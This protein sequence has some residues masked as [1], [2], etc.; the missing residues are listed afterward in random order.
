MLIVYEET[1]AHW[2]MSIENRSEFIMNEDASKNYF[3]Y[4]ASYYFNRGLAG[5]LSNY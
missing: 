5:V 2:M 4:L 1:H 3:L